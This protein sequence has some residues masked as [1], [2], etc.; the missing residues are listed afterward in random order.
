[1]SP[2][3][4]HD[5]DGPRREREQKTRDE[6]ACIIGGET[7]YAKAT[8]RPEVL[9]RWNDI[10]D[11]TPMDEILKITDETII[12]LLENVDDTPERYRAMRAN[13]DD[14]V[15][16]QDILELAKWLVEVQTGRPIEPPSDSST[17]PGTTENGTGSTEPSSLPETQPEPAAST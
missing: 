14:P 15:G 13:E 9:A 2:S 3:T 11:D 10:G 17:S 1:M 16:F 4:P 5:F 12:A 6:R 8:V 7:F